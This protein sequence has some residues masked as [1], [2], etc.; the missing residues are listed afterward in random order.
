MLIQDL[1]YL[2]TAEDNSI[3]GGS[4]GT[5]AIVTVV[6]VGPSA[7]TF[8]ATGAGVSLDVLGP[9][10][11]FDAASATA[12]GTGAGLLGFGGT[13]AITTITV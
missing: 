1:A 7:A 12:T 2:E 5:S 3:Q 11:S 10:F 8:T 13:G 6:G 4:T 9:F